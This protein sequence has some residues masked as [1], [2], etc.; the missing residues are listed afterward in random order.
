MRDRVKPILYL[1][2]FAS[3]P[4]GRKVA[5][6]KE[7]LEPEGFEVVA[8]DLN[9]PS[10][11]R[12]S[13][14]AMSETAAA[15]LT[16]HSPAVVVGSSLGALVA[17]QAVHIGHAVP[18]VLIAPALGFGTRWTEK[19]PPGDPVRFFHFGENRELLIHRGFFEE[20]AGV[21][22]D[23]YPPEV[24]VTVVM[25]TRDDSVPV[26]LV[27]GV[28]KRW[29]ISGRLV[30]GSRFV[31]VPGGDHGLVDNVGLLANEIRS[32]AMG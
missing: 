13:F 4:N 32:A 2:G 18:L 10:F 24:A 20:M 9:V 23:L 30:P 19:L 8:P 15:A 6:L 7:T 28:W 27:E 14:E 3:S 31:S 29:E 12:L 26:D 17:L 21:D 25:G 5:A 1:H 22:V 16:K 11:E